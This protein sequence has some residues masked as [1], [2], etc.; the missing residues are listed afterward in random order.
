MIGG[1]IVGP[2][3]FKI[4]GTLRKSRVA[5]SK[6]YFLVVMNMT[7]NTPVR[8]VSSSPC[9]SDRK[10]HMTTP[11]RHVIYLKENGWVGTF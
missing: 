7:K 6:E 10:K 3:K 9:R 5:F 11:S 4:Q 2:G 8:D 1:R